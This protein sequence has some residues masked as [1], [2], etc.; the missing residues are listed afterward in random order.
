MELVLVRCLV[1]HRGPSTGPTCNR[2]ERLQCSMFLFAFNRCPKGPEHWAAQGR[3]PENSLLFV[4][5]SLLGLQK[6]PARLLREFGC[7][8]LNLPADLAPK[9]TT[10]GGF[11]EIPC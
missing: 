9:T 11:C 7:K 10:R 6:F 5:N 8:P 3:I 1:V 4:Q 2:H